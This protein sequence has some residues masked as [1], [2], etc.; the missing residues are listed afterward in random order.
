MT[1]DPGGD[2]DRYDPAR[3]GAAPTG[4]LDPAGDP[5]RYQSPAGGPTLPGLL[6]EG[7]FE[8]QRDSFT[9]VLGLIGVLLFLGFVSMMIILLPH[10]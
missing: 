9:W 5:D 4:P 3:D 10:S 7:A 2:P 1:L 8:D 6:G